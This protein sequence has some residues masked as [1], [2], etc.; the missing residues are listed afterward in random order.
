MPR[1]S[2][3]SRDQAIGM[4]MTGATQDDVARRFRV[5]PSTISRLQRRFQDTGVTR[6]RP[7][8]GQPRVITRA[9]DRYIRTT[10]LRDR[11]RA[12]AHTAAETRGRT[13]PKV[14][15]RTVSHRLREEGIRPYR[16]RDCFGGGGVMVWGA[17]GHGWR[18]ALVF[19]EGAL[20][21]RRY[22]DLIATMWYPT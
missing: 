16:A 18:S 4:L 7:R 8:P 22:I 14:C 12:A 20:N 6:D 17:I 19:V 13:Q 1:M 9:Q 11:F 3:V 5:A 10:H 21:A 15:P 2:Q